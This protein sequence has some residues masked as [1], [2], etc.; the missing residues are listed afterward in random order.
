MGGSK[1][2][3]NI[4]QIFTGAGPPCACC[5]C[6]PGGSWWGAVGGWFPIGGYEPGGCRIKILGNTLNDLDQFATGMPITNIN[7]FCEL[8]HHWETIDQLDNNLTGPPCPTLCEEG[9]VL[10]GIGPADECAELTAELADPVEPGLCGEAPS[11][12]PPGGWTT[13]DDEFVGLWGDEP[14]V[15]LPPATFAPPWLC[16]AGGT[17]PVLEAGGAVLVG[18]VRPLLEEG[19]GC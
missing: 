18:G 13:G 11:L 17:T 1:L 19:G 4:S 2:H 9:P 8:R 10:G 14:A 15:L 7:I 12:P 6:G 5:G 16:V 3:C